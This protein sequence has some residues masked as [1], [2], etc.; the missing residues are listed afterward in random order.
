MVGDREGW[1]LGSACPIV[2]PNKSGLVGYIQ[3][4]EI[5]NPH[6]PQLHHGYIDAAPDSAG[7]SDAEGEVKSDVFYFVSLFAHFYRYYVSKN[8]SLQFA[9]VRFFK[10]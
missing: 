1:L 7:F 2:T 6:E 3:D 8:I 10:N 9:S 4:K 5:V